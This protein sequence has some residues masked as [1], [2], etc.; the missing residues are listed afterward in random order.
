[1][2]P[3][4]HTILDLYTKTKL[5]TSLASLTKNSRKSDASGKA[6]KWQHACLLLDAYWVLKVNTDQFRYRSLPSGFPIVLMDIDS[7]GVLP[8]SFEGG[9]CDEDWDLGVGCGD[10]VAWSVDESREPSSRTSDTSVADLD[11]LRN[12]SEK[13]GCDWEVENLGPKD[14]N[15]G[16]LPDW[17]GVSHVYIW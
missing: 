1:M 16:K 6:K 14:V 4:S 3:L 7:D 11:G 2:S 13:V 12:W 15:W 9:A 8:K 10:W 5:R 17:E